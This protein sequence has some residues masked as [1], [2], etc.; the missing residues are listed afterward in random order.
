MLATSYDDGLPVA[1]SVIDSRDSPWPTFLCHRGRFSSKTLTNLGVSRRP[2]YRGLFPLNRSQPFRN[3]PPTRLVATTANRRLSL[4]NTLDPGPTRQHA[5]TARY[6]SRRTGSS[7]P[8]TLSD[9]CCRTFPAAR[10]SIDTRSTT[11]PTTASV[12]AACCSAVPGRSHIGIESARHTPARPP[13]P[14]LNSPSPLRL[15][16]RIVACSVVLLWVLDQMESIVA[17]CGQTSLQRSL[18]RPIVFVTDGYRGEVTDPDWAISATSR[19][20]AATAAHPRRSALP[21]LQPRPY[22][23]W[24]ATC[25]LLAEDW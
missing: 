23:I 24:F 7:L 10:G 4:G 8:R 21:L 3:L 15:L 6:H 14:S 13:A 9:P 22:P 19:S 17:L 12:P 18:C 1:L 20:F 11:D 16:R 5:P 25:G 2:G